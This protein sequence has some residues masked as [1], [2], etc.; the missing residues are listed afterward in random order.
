MR[1]A[2]F[3]L[4]LL[5]SALILSPAAHADTITFSVSVIGSG[6]V[7]DTSFTDQRVT[8]A[9]S[10]PAQLVADAI[11]FNLGTPSSFGICFDDGAT[12]TVQG[13]GTFGGPD[14]PCVFHNFEAPDNSYVIVDGENDLGI[15]VPLDFDSLQ[16]SVGPVSGTASVDLGPCFVGGEVLSC[17]PFFNTSGGELTLTS[18]EA[19]TGVAELLVTSP[20]PEPSTFVLLATGFL[21]VG[22][23]LRRARSI[24]A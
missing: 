19:S 18:Y 24:N 7:G 9:V 20:T 23:L 10:E 12:A 2:L 3:A 6:S 13:I 17:P 4:P 21:G 15:S 16:Y 8:F 11:T 1:K 5:A 22:C 14:L